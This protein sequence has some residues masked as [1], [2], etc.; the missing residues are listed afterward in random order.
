MQLV[1]KIEF[2]RI[3]A[4]GKF[5]PEIDG[6]RFVA[7]ASVLLY[8][9][10][11]FLR[12]KNLNPYLVN[13]NKSY[14]PDFIVNGSLGVELFF[15]ISGFILGLFFAKAYKNDKTVSHKSYFIRRLTRLEPP[16][17]LAMILLFFGSV[18]VAGNLSVAEA[19]KSLIA[20]LLYS[21]NI[22]YP[23][24]FP[25][26]MAAA[27]SLE[28]E[29]QFYILA[30]LLGLI[31]KWKNIFN[32]RIV[33]LLGIFFLAIFP[34]Y[35]PLPFVS[36]YDFMEYFLLGFLITD[37]FTEK[38]H[39][40]KTWP[41]VPSTLL[42][43]LLLYFYFG[44]KSHEATSEVNTLLNLLQL[45]LL[46][47]VFYLTV[48]KES[49]PFLKMRWLTNIG[50]ACYSI[51][52]LHFPIISMAGNIIV[53]YKCTENKLIDNLIFGT[54]LL[55]LSLVISGIFYLLIERPCMDKNWY[56]KFMPSKEIS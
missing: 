14:A 44:L 52:L 41:S 27:W 33:L 29:V 32:R 34:H 37:L 5:I 35:F 26:L 49:V 43:F 53:K 7:I 6:L 31:F 2:R 1:K 38:L 28:I 50:G 55:I 19:G 13:S 25:K 36:I 10:H 39:Q 30:P 4:Q 20:S 17:I 48:L 15:V 42:F 54:I 45:P 8:H 23:G 18:F 56:K 3:I 46:F 51:Y 11:I 9:I 24:E 40:K 21:H 16:Y 47:G 22:V 12:D